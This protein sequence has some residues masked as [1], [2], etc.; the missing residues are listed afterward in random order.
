MVM[1]F[2]SV[3]HLKVS[4]S[5]IPF[6]ICRN[7]SKINPDT[8]MQQRHVSFHIYKNRFIGY[9]PDLSTH[10]FMSDATRKPKFSVNT[11]A[12]DSDIQHGC[13][14]CWYY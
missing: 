2:F 1:L 4:A 5:R 14:L 10:L 8:G 11:K 7:T 3:K 13:K 9:D 12:Y 6:M